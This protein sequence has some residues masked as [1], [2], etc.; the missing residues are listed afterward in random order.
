MSRAR[1]PWMLEADAARAAREAEIKAARKARGSRVFAVLPWRSGRYH[2]GDVIKWHRTRSAAEKHGESINGGQ[3]IVVKEWFDIV[4]PDV[5][6]T[7]K[8][9]AQ[10]DAEIDAALD[11]VGHHVMLSV[12]GSPW[13]YVGS[14]GGGTTSPDL[15]VDFKS[16]EAAEVYM[17]RATGP[18]SSVKMRYVTRSRQR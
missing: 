4:D 1:L 15:A 16:R 6:K 18:R 2:G 17:T 12:P 13:V 3:G 10:L 14:S 9:A 7:V 5:V 8:S 11:D